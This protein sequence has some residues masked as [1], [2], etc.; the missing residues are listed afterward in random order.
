LVG[1]CVS[2][3]WGKVIGVEV[4]TSSTFLAAKRWSQKAAT[5]K[6]QPNSHRHAHGLPELGA[7][8]QAVDAHRT[9]HLGGCACGKQVRTQWGVH[10]NA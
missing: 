9:L 10:V 6:S 8:A 5:A 7:T 3:R 4:K 2:V 1:G